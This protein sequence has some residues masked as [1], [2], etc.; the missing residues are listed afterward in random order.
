MFFRCLTKDIHC[1]FIHYFCCDDY[2]HL[3]YLGSWTQTHITFRTQHSRTNAAIQ[4]N[5]TYWTVARFCSRLHWV[6]TIV[7]P[8]CGTYRVQVRLSWL[9]CIVL[10]RVW[11]D[12][13]G[14]LDWWLDLL[15]ILTHDSCLYLIIAPS[16]SSTLYKSLQHT[17][18]LFSLLYLHQ[19]SPGNGF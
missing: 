10:S 7:P 18:S 9:R 14:V 1:N 12:I 6:I 3:Q 19:S 17:L 11:V 15:T 8:V 2:V 4:C 5:F 16:P 13:D